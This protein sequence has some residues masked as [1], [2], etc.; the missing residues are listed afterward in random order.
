MGIQ[1]YIKGLEKLVVDNSPTILTAVGVVGI[2]GTGVLSYRAGYQQGTD[3]AVGGVPDNKLEYVKRS[4]KRHVLPVG[5]GALTVGAVVGANRISV[6]RTVALASAYALTN[7]KFSDYREKVEAKL[8][9]K[10]TDEVKTEIAQEKVDNNPPPQHIIIS[11][12]AE[13]MCLDLWSMTYF[14]SDV[15]TIRKAVNDINIQ[16]MNSQYASLSDFYEKLGITPGR[17]SD[18]LGWNTDSML[19]VSFNSVLTEDH[20]AVLTVDFEHEPIRGYGKCY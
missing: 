5:T 12:D 9:K 20:R 4:W 6:S 16:I 19:E 8:G 7:E 15:E 10:K 13:Q 14:K 11:S 18:E 3:D 2:V 17:M 1:L